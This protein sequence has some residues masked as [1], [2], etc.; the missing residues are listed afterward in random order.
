MG[1]KFVTEGY[2]IIDMVEDGGAAV[3]AES[4]PIETG[5]SD[6]ENGLFV[7]LQSWDEDTVHADFNLIR[8]KKVR[9][10]IEEID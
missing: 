9:I 7:K 6:E 2:V 5:N 10:T 8:G 4:F 3:I 1:L